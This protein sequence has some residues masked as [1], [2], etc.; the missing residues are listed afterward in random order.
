MNFDT[1]IENA[2]PY[3]A[4]AALIGT[5]LMFLG[6]IGGAVG[7]T[8]QFPS[9]LIDAYQ[10][11]RDAYRA[12]K[13]SNE[14]DKRRY[15][16]SAL[17]NGVELA[18]GLGGTK[19]AK[20]GLQKAA[21]KKPQN[22]LK[23]PKPSLITRSNRRNYQNKKQAYDKFWIDTRNMAEQQLKDSGYPR[24]TSSVLQTRANTIAHRRMNDLYAD[25]TNKS[26]L[27][28]KKATP[29][30]ENTVFQIPNIKDILK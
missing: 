15:T 23:K 8:L 18:M 16:M 17:G 28:A 30:V 7:K 26:I 13:S 27:F 11:T 25:A 1:F 20:F 3:A 22:F 4:G 9:I 24:I 10:A 2:E 14:K 5:P 12:Y 21:F 19:I 6:P 29:Y